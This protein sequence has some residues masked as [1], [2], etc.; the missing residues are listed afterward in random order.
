MKKYDRLDGFPSVAS[1]G[2]GGQTVEC[3][4]CLCYKDMFDRA[5]AEY[6]Q[7]GGSLAGLMHGVMLKR[8]GHHVHLIEQNL[9]STRTDNAAGIGTG[10][11]GAQFFKE[12]DLY[13]SLY[14]FS[15]PGFNI[16]DKDSN[17]KRVLNIPLNLTSW[18][19]LY[20]R[21]RANFDGLQSE[22]YPALTSAP[23]SDG[24]AVYELGKR[25]TNVVS[26]DQLVTVEFEDLQTK[27][28]RTLHAD[29][30]I[31]ADGQNSII[32]EKFMP[33]QGEQ[34]YAGYVVWRGTVPEK[35]VSEATRKLFGERF[36]VFAMSRGYIG[37]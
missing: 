28:S 35:D 29:L 10:P 6:K 23:A 4:Y 18:N 27:G 24:E 8:L 33:N 36:N 34:P 25:A 1:S 11:M 7:I 31:V 13:P 26:T 12:H 37:G 17:V 32:R 30:V 22:Y 19:V 21:L 15:C 20:Y 5:P 2:P 14:S 9:S 3:G 16:L